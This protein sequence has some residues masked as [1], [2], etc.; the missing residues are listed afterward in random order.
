M[1]R[2]TQSNAL[3][4]GNRWMSG[5]AALFK[6]TALRRDSGADAA[7]FASEGYIRFEHPLT[8]PSS[9]R[10]AGCHSPSPIL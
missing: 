6:A 2:E 5:K 8:H 10:E 3:I 1:T 7:L 4:H 9:A